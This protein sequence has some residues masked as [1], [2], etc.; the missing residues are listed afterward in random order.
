MTHILVVPLGTGGPDTLTLA[1]ADALR[2]AKRLILRTARH[3]MAAWLKAQGVAFESLDELYEQSEDFDAFNRAVAARL[4]KLDGETA[5]AVS[6]PAFD[7]TVAALR[8][9]QPDAV[10]VLPG[11]SH[12]ARCLAL[13]SSAPCGLRVY[14]ASE[15]ADARVS[16]GEPL[17]LT[18]LHSREC[19]GDCKL[20]LLTLMNDE[21]PVTFFSG[22]KASRLTSAVVP[23]YE[24]DRQA[25]Y[26]HLTAVYVPPEPMLERSRR[27]M[28]DLLEV[29]RRLRAPGGCPWDRE[30]THESLLSSLLEE[31]YEFIDAVKKGESDPMY[32]ELGDVLLQVAFHAEI[33][34]QHGDFDFTDVTSAICQKMIERHTHIFGGARADTSA[35]VLDNWE[36]FKRE[37]RGIHSVSEAMDDVSTGLS[38]AM[39][40]CKIQHKAAKVG[41]DFASAADALQKVREETEETAACLAGADGLEMELG[42]LFFSMVNVAR[43]CGVSPDVALHLSTQ[44]FM[45][46]FRGMEKSI[47]KAGKSIEG[48][49]LSEMDVYWE[50][51]KRQA[52]TP[53]GA[54]DS[55]FSDGF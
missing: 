26:D 33:A 37:Q 22:D 9:E 32:D 29:M 54:R 1:A 44:K 46:R 14:P 16:P 35:Q 27:D 5:Y 23:L 42:D 24:L 40:A 10:T 28:D 31:S 53:D 15:F 47:K 41:F 49:T 55:G 19:A 21:L 45:A 34:R 48:L 52:S 50:S 2:G 38:A 43:L 4:L 13:L 12:A 20:R 17:L 39:Y 6:D 25:A 3:P 11:V 18:E 8:R 7:E 51:E 36:S 30:Q